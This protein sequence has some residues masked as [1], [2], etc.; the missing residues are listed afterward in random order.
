M[1]TG[2]PTS[3]LAAVNTPSAT[4]IIL[5]TALYSRTNRQTSGQRRCACFVAHHQSRSRMGLR[6][7]HRR[8][9]RALGRL[10]R[11]STIAIIAEWVCRQPVL[12]QVPSQTYRPT[13]TGRRN[14]LDR[15]HKHKA[16]VLAFMYDFHIPFDNN[17]VE[18]ACA[19]DDRTVCKVSGCTT[20]FRSIRG[21][22]NQFC[23]I[24][25]Y[26]STARKHGLAM[27]LMPSTM[28]SLDQPC[29]PSSNMAEWLPLTRKTIAVIRNITF[30]GLDIWQYD[31]PNVTRGVLR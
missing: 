28:L 29:I 11:P 6:T 8:A 14:L 3:S 20:G 12:R 25:S 13:Q 19:H 5:R 2:P 16:G 21:C 10:Q 1:T 7:A 23:D 9:P 31:I 17:L 4:S 22:P 15:L 18:R 30:R 26:I 27:P 24:R